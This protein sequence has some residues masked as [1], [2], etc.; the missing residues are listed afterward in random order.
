MEF[1]SQNT[2]VG[3]LSL[4]QGIFPIPYWDLYKW[5]HG[6]FVNK[7]SLNYGILRVP[8]SC[9]ELDL[10]RDLERLKFICCSFFYN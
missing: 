8:A 5:A 3:S 10:Y 2:L 7:L 4:L 6:P 9:W 1:S